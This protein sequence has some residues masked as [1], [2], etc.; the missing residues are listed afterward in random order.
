[1]DDTLNMLLDA[2]ADKLMERLQNP[3]KDLYTARELAERYGVSAATI[4]NKMAAGEFGELV[5]MGE[6]T[7]LV[8]WAGVKAYEAMHLEQPKR[9]PTAARRNHRPPPRGNPGPI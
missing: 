1:M 6:R 4:R 3:H 7:R 2:L 5:N 9:R 8:P